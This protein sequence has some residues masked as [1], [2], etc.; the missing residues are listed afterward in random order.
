MKLIRWSYFYS[1]TETILEALQ[2]SRY[3]R[4]LREAKKEAIGD[5]PYQTTY[6]KIFV[7]IAGKNDPL[8]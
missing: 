8:R 5:F 2:D 4:T 3:G 1:D 6:I 7:E